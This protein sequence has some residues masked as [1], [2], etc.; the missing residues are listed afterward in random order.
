MGGG[1][2]F[3][4]RTTKTTTFLTSSLKKILNYVYTHIQLICWYVKWN[5]WDIIFSDLYR[6]NQNHFLIPINLINLLYCLY[7]PGKSPAS[8]CLLHNDEAGDPQARA[9]I[10]IHPSRSSLWEGR[11][12]SWTRPVIL[13]SFIFPWY[14][15]SRI[16]SSIIGISL[17]KTGKYILW[18]YLHVCVF[19]SFFGKFKDFILNPQSLYFHFLL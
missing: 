16:P 17:C 14:W 3:M 8:H 1:G 19:S 13:A 2:D 12:S 5:K 6:A 15:L 7:I 10:P 9:R 18:I 4:V 11:R